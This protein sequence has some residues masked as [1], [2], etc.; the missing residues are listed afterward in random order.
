MMNEKVRDLIYLD[1]KR[2]ISIQSLRVLYWAISI[3]PLIMITWGIVAIN[4]I[5]INWRSLFPLISITVWSLLYWTLVLTVQRKK[6]KKTFELRFLVNGLSGLLISS[7]FWILYSSLS[8]LNN[9]PLISFDFLLWILLFYFL[10][11]VLYIGLVVLGTHKGIYKKIKK[12]SQTPKALAISAFFAAILPTTGVMGMYTSRVLR[13]YASAAVQD[14]VGTIALVLVIFLPILG[15]INF[16]QY[17]YC[18]KYKIFCDENGNST[19]PNLEHQR[20]RKGIK[21]KKEEFNQADVSGSKTR[22]KK[23]PLVIKVLIAILGVPI[24]FFVIVFIVFFIKGFI[25]GIT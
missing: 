24:V 8:L 2:Y 14:F 11:S 7:L 16:V 15:H 12:K 25:Q 18:K 19:S 22:N 10:S 20:K 6:S 5:G 17:F 9:N 1:S 13:A 3:I 23:I 4:T 21:A